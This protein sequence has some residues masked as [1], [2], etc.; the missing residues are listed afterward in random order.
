[1]ERMAAKYF[2]SL[3]N[4]WNIRLAFPSHSCDQPWPD[5]KD[6][7]KWMRVYEECEAQQRAAYT[8]LEKGGP[9]AQPWV[10]FYLERLEEYEPVSQANLRKEWTE[11]GLIPREVKAK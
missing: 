7:D 4:H 10:D 1:M 8:A 6:Y 9:T 11:E 5:E 2:P 3:L